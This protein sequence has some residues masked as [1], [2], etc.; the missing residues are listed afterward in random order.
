MANYRL[1]L[2]EQETSISWMADEKTARIYTNIP[3][4]MRKLDKLCDKH[5]DVYKLE[6]LDEDS[7]SYIIPKRLIS[8]RSPQEKREITEEQRIILRERFAKAKLNLEDDK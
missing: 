4:T 3:A 7:K 2:C 5:P 1:Q 6:Q 8:F